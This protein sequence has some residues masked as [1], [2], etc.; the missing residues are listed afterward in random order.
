MKSIAKKIIKYR[1]NKRFWQNT[2]NFQT[3]KKKKLA[4]GYANKYQS[5]KI[6][7]LY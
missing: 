1:N 3:K 7:E 2:K 4:I 6:K 5:K